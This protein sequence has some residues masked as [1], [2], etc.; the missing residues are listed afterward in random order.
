MS[1]L[2]I[3]CKILDQEFYAE[4]GMPSYGT[5]YS[6]GLDLRANLETPELTLAP[7]ETKLIR[8]GLSLFINNK[9]YAGF[10]YPR[11]GLGHKQGLVL[12]N[13]VGVIDADYQGEIMI[14]FWNRSSE[15]Q[16]IKRGDRIAQLVIQP[17][18]QCKLDIIENDFV[19]SE[20][21]EGG[22]GSTGKS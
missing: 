17:I 16:V 12:G 4:F 1:K 8:T 7:G 19:K 10:I 6:A 9:K 20:R 3:Q 14:S 5:E 21:G 13:L 2:N 18:L 22:W 15:P 11:S